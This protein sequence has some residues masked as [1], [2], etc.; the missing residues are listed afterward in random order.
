LITRTSLKGTAVDLMEIEP[1]ATIDRLEGPGMH[2]TKTIAH[3]GAA[4]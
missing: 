3:G 1:M 4:K 2:S